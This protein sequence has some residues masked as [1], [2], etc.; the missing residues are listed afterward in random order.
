MPAAGR[1]HSGYILHVCRDHFGLIPVFRTEPSTILVFSHRQ[2][3]LPW[4]LAPSL[5]NHSSQAA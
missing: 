1:R 5:H 4:N 3:L 2:D